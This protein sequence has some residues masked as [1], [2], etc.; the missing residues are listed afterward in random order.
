M[1]VELIGIP[2]EPES[3]YPGLPNIRRKEILTLVE[4]SCLCGLGV[5]ELK[6][7]IQEERLIAEWRGR[8]EIRQKEL[9]RFM[10]A[11]GMPYRIIHELEKGW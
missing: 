4:A 11:A 10:R 8:Y 1:D 5:H 3:E 7:A 6:E 2:A 9:I